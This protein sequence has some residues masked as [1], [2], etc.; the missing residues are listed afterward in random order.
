[1]TEETSNENQEIVEVSPEE[2]REASEMGWA[3]LDKWRGDPADWVDAKTFL[4]RGR[5]TLKTTA[6]RAS[7]AEA[8]AIAA[9]RAARAA[10]AA[11]EAAAEERAEEQ[12]EEAQQTLTDLK[13]AIATASRDGDHEAVANLTEKMVD[14][15]AEIAEKKAPKKGGDAGNTGPHPEVVSW[16]SANQEYVTN[17]RRRALMEGIMTEMRQAGDSRVGKVFLDAA[18]AE[19]DKTLGGKGAGISRVAAGNGGQ[20]QGSDGGMKKSYADLPAEAKQA[21]DRMEARLV[22]QGKKHKDAAS[23]RA[24][25]TKKYFEGEAS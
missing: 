14:L 6:E 11:L 9:E 10:T 23:W 15:K 18:A 5:H 4:S 25:Y 24:S 2:L 1:M 22:G 7:V 3:A 12:V 8:R 21:C 13:A 20:R 19:V 16:F 17:P